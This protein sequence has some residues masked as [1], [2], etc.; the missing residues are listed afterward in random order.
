MKLAEGQIE[1]MKEDMKIRISIDFAKQLMISLQIG[2]QKKK[3]ILIKCVIILVE[4]LH[5]FYMI[6]K[7]YREK[8]GIFVGIGQ[9]I[10]VS[11]NWDIQIIIS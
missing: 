3:L 7:S 8:I 1:I 5:S 2:V 11:T 9:C 10:T 6:K 4:L